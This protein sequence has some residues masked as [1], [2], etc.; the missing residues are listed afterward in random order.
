MKPL[1]VAN[2]KW[3]MAPEFLKRYSSWSVKCS[4]V[5]LAKD[6]MAII[7]NIDGGTCEM[8]QELSNW[9][10]ETNKNRLGVVTTSKGGFNF[11]VT[12]LQKIQA[13]DVAFNIY[14]TS[15]TVI[16][17]ISILI[18]RIDRYHVK[19]SMKGE[20]KREMKGK[21]KNERCGPKLVL[22]FFLYLPMNMLQHNLYF[23]VTDNCIFNIPILKRKNKAIFSFTPGTRRLPF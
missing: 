22:I 3:R 19:E 15:E 6:Q 20:R 10:V 7:E 2:F 13:S 4:G 1:P 21:G 9:N 5:T 16:L 11:N 23:H 18:L 8:V 17:M 12:N 14:K